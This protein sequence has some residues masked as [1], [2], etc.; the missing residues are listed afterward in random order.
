MTGANPAITMQAGIARS[1]AIPETA[2]GPKSRG[3]RESAVGGELLVGLAVG[4]AYLAATALTLGQLGM[5]LAVAAAAIAIASP[6]AGLATLTLI[7]PMRESGAFPLNLSTVMMSATALG[8][9]LRLPRD[10]NA[11]F[12]HPG[13]IVAIGYAVL[14]LLSVLPTVS[15]RPDTWVTEAGAQLSNVVAAVGIFIV[16]SYMFRSLSPRPILA[17][18]L[19]SAFL[20]ALLALS[21][22]WKVGPVSA[23]EG[24]LEPTRGERATAGFSG[25]NYLGFFLAQASLL[26]IGVWSVTS[27]RLR[28]LLLIVLVTL[29]V[30]LAVSYSRSAYIGVTV[31]VVVLAALHRNRTTALV[32]VIVAIAAVLLLYPTFNEVRQGTGVFGPSAVIGREQSENWRRLA[33]D[34]GLAMFLS[35]P[36]F[37][38]GFGMFQ[39]ISP[40]YIG[41]SPATASHNAY[42]Q[43]LAEQGIVGAAMVAGIIAMLVAALWRS[44]NP[45]RIPA[46]AMLSCYLVQSWFINST[47]SI[48]ISGLTWITMAAALSAAGRVPDIQ[49]QGA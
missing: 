25:P 46:L 45:L 14:S 26:A 38:V 20:V 18:G 32:I 29:L 27:R 41:G 28:P 10:R 23:L 4:L 49:A 39:F 7:L 36:V 11:L 35:A 8:C 21:A 24:L 31:G 5:S 34:A 13:V 42:V 12:V 44:V 48:E 3:I 22:Y 37:G 15:G 47:I 1:V 9:I 17:I 16:A 40:A 30:G 19:G 43:I 33:A 2:T 6:V